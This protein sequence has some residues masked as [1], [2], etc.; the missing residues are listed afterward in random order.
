MPKWLTSNRQ[1]RTWFVFSLRHVIYSDF[2]P[3]SSKQA[4]IQKHLKLKS[5]CK[6]ASYKIIASQWMCVCHCAFF[7][8]FRIY[9][10][11]LCFKI[12]DMCLCILRSVPFSVAMFCINWLSVK[13]KTELEST[14]MRE[15]KTST[16]VRHQN[17]TTTT[18]IIAFSG[19]NLVGVSQ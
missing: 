1:S 16:N 12:F 11:L 18:T 9:N 14:N 15:K 19:N 8:S 5:C 10:R 7:S 6:M 17:T 4:Q 13:N 3:P 2:F